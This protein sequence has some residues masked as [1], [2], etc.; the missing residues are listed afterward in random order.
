MRLSKSEWEE[1]CRESDAM[2]E[3]GVQV[4][5]VLIC[6]EGARPKRH[7]YTKKP[8]VRITEHSIIDGTGPRFFIHGYRMGL[9]AYV[10]A[11]IQDQDETRTIEPGTKFRVVEKFKSSVVLEQI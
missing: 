9:V 5:D 4:G 6:D 8:H 2:R 3:R 10:P 1:Y 7:E 11:F